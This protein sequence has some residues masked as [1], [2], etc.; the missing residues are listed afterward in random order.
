L[1]SVGE[2]QDQPNV[3]SIVRAVAEKSPWSVLEQR[4]KIQA[5][6][7]GKVEKID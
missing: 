6:G 2:F 7:F 4:G 1:K 3:E 5:L